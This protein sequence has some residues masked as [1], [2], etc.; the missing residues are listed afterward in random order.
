MR[1]T[2]EVVDVSYSLLHP[3][4]RNLQL[5]AEQLSLLLVP[6]VKNQLRQEDE[7]WLAEV[8]AGVLYA[9]QTAVE[10]FTDFRI[11]EISGQS[12]RSESLCTF[13]RKTVKTIMEKPGFL[14]EV[15]LPVEAVF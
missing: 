10:L 12:G 6:V 8:G 7:A 5:P 1:A 11:H 14:E 2:S 3:T 9:L 15:R 13:V 4:A